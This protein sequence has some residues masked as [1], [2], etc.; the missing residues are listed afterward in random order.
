MPTNRQTRRFCVLTTG[1]S[2]STSLMNC[3]ATFNDIALPCKDVDC[4]DNELLHPA[5]ANNYARL[6][7]QRYNQPVHTLHDLIECFYAAHTAENFVGFKSMLDR[8]TDLPA[9]TLR[10]DIQFITLI[11]ED[12]ASTVASFMLAMHTGSWRRFGEPQSACWNFNQQRDAQ[13]V[14]GNLN[15]V[16]KS[17]DAMRSIPGAI[18][19]TYEALCVPEFNDPA[20]NHF[21]ARQVRLANPRPPTHGSSYVNNWE[22][23]FAFIQSN[24]TRKS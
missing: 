6:Y 20:L 24:I 11:R 3:L 5:R 19:L 12:I 4:I 13:R 17:N 7:A 21:F 2:G 14:L 18:A 15:Y 1:R 8:H 23:F 9:F 16:L 22:E 10:Q